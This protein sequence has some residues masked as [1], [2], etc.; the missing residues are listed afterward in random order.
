MSQRSASA[1]VIMRGGLC[2]TVWAKKQQAVSRST[3]DSELYVAVKTA[4]EG[5][6]IQRVAKDLGTVCGLHL[7]LDATVTKCLVNRRGLANAKHVDMQNLRIQKGLQVKKVRREEGGYERE[8]L[9][10]QMT[11]PMHGT[12]DRAG[13]ENHGL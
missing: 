2:L 12:K 5:L 8:P 9:P 6:G 3:A 1:G 13:Y 10:T 4:S 11:K 7:H